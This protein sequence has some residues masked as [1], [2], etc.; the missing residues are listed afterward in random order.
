MSAPAQNGP[1]WRNNQFSRASQSP[2][3]GPQSSN[4]PKASVTSPLK[5]QPSGHV[6]Q[7]SLEP[8]GSP[9]AL[10]RSNSFRRHSHR[11]STPQAGTFAPQ[12]I[13]SEEMQSPPYRAG[14]IEGENDLSGKRYVWV[15]DPQSAFIKGWVVEELAG[16]RLLVQCDDGSVG[17]QS[18][19]CA[20]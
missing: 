10:G 2:S 6:R 8:F 18:S 4:W 9:Q 7:Q 15:K 13:K 17:F 14:R 19:P 5:D 1:R 16:D 3:P 20:F 11:G 12:F